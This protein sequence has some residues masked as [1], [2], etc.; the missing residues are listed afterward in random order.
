[1]TLPMPETWGT[2]SNG[3]YGDVS[4]WHIASFRCPAEFC[5][6]RGIADM[7][8]INPCDLP[9]G[10]FA[11]FAVQSR[12]QKYFVSLFARNSFIDSPSRPH[13][14]GVSRSSRT[15]GRDAVDAGG[16]SDEGACLRT[17]K[18]CG[19]DASTLASSFAEQSVQATVANK[20]GHRGEPE[21][22]R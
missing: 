3:R 9:D 16:A 2:K 21:G 12:L 15:L 13:K 20:P 4:Y 19:P 17:A 1:V 10:L 14:R 6:Y 22:N 7:G 5:R 11:I 18:S 8:P